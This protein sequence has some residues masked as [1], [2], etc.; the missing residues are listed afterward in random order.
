M[1]G[2]IPK[3][4][5]VNAAFRT[6]VDALEDLCGYVLRGND[7][8]AHKQ[9]AIVERCVT[10]IMDCL[11]EVP[12]TPMYSPEMGKGGQMLPLCG[13]C[14]ESDGVNIKSS[15]YADTD[16]PTHLCNKCCTSTTEMAASSIDL[17]H[18]RG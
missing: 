17:T 7:V 13:Y 9:K 15:K 16:E 10:G 12:A 8:R 11:A 2:M 4:H 5:R 6:G 18:Y 3:K 1:D 14:T